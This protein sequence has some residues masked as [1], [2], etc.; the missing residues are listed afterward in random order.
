[1]SHVEEYSA[2]RALHP[3]GRPYAPT[4][5]PLA[6]AL[7]RGETIANEELTYVAG[8]GTRRLHRASAAPIRDR[9]QR[10][11]AALVV[12]TDI[13][14]ERLREQQSGQTQRLE[15]I[16]KLAGGV[17]HDFNNLLTVVIGASSL[18]LE[19]LRP[20]ERVRE[21][22]ETINECGQRA[23][24]LTRQLL[25]FSRRQLLQPKVIDLNTIVPALAKMLQRL[26]GEDVELTTRLGSSLGRIKA[27]PGQVEQ[28]ITNLAVN[29][30]DAMPHGGKLVIETSNVELDRDYALHHVDIQPG[31]HVMLA[32]SDTGLGMDRE[33]QSR[34]F[35]P[36]FTT[37]ARGHGT[38]L[39]LATVYGIVKQSGGHIWVYS[40]EAQGT[41]FKVY[42]PRVDDAA[43]PLGAVT[44]LVRRAGTETILL[45]ED[46]D[47]VRQLVRDVLGR[48]GYTVMECRNGAEAEFMA[49]NF[50]GTIHLLIT[51]VVMP[52]RSGRELAKV[53]RVSRPQIGVLFMSGYT[54]NA[55]AHHGVIDADVEFLEKPFT[56]DQ[57]LHRVRRII[58]G[59]R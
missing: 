58:D 19:E 15:A 3:D 22:L 14:E 47:V 24:D 29:A 32:V 46:E 56:P 30:R 35:E 7:L 34:I 25:A 33:T 41:T 53:L 50:G 11:V 42:F 38:G 18:A 51:D 17:A 57:L 16:G 52:G 40:E 12:F 31:P 1:V 54:D 28:I 13:T 26:L 2:Y 6:R 5:Y 44:G 59:A 37:K 43:E 9:D 36:F 55:I 4:E 10:I 39:G 8:D 20:D 23:A 49:S 21:T 45:V 48:A 27:D